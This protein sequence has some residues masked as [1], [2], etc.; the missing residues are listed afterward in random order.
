MKNNLRIKK[1]ITLFLTFMKIGAFTFGGGYAMIPLIQR[2]TVEHHHWVTDSDILDLLAIAEATPGVIAVNSA[3]FIGY[4]V[5]GF[6]G[7]L[8]ATLGVV[9]PSFVTISIL[10]LF[11]MQYKQIKWL[12]WVFDG[13]RAGVV[14]LIVNAVIKIKHQC[15]KDKF[16]SIIMILAFSAAAFINMDVI[17]IL[18]AAA[19]AGV[20]RQ[21]LLLKKVSKGGG[22][23][24]V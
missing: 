23:G 9:L 22:D 10:S 1:C 24:N 21:M 19:A 17:L 15:A 2:E 4:R 7:A 3:T 18:I 6:F 13:I 16:N 11:I 20:V 8:V 5:A 14:V 12:T